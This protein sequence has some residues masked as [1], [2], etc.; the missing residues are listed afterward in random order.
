M[1]VPLP[2]VTLPYAASHLLRVT[3]LRPAPLHH[4]I[5][6]P[7]RTTP[8]QH[9]TLHYHGTTIQNHTSTAQDAAKPHLYATVHN[10]ATTLLYVTS[11]RL[12]STRLNKTLPVPY[13][14]IQYHHSTAPGS[15]VPSQ[16]CTVLH[17]TLPAQYSAQ[18]YLNCTTRRHTIAMRNITL[19]V[20]N[21]TSQYHYVTVHYATQPYR[22]IPR[23]ALP[24]L[25]IT[26]LYQSATR[27][28]ITIPPPNIRSSRKRRIRGR[29][30]ATG[31][32]L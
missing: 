27:R 11:H 22:T 26:L 25:D 15:T 5:A 14:A 29:R 4:R 31:Q 13:H 32:D 2:Y 3:Q 9:V 17:F 1:T 28:H 21:Y 19:P 30:C 23:P 12:Y 16:N 6:W 7:N 18:R 10:L 20:P 8:K 24:W